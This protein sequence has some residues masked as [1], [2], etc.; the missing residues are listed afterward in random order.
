MS[1]RQLAAVINGFVLTPCSR[2]RNERPLQT[3]FD[4]RK[5]QEIVSGGVLF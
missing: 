5:E 3:P 4:L 2:Q 1:S